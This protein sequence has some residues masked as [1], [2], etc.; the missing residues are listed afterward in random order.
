M[1]EK[2][3]TAT[4]EIIQ[5]GIYSEAQ[6]TNKEHF[7]I[8]SLNTLSMS[9]IF[10]K[11]Q[12]FLQQHPLDIINWSETWLRNDPNV[13]NCVQ[14]PVCNFCCKSHDERPDGSVIPYIKGKINCKEQRDASRSIETM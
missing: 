14:M 3:V 9:Y 6:E 5:N 7:I 12:V 4:G 8:S 1:L 2:N 10:D 13:L 11:F